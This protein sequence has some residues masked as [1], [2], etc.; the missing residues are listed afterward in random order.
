ME[1]FYIEKIFW[2]EQ[3]V[4][5]ISPLYPWVSDRSHLG[6]VTITASKPRGGFPNPNSQTSW[7]L[8]LGAGKLEFKSVVLIGLTWSRGEERLNLRNP[9]F[10]QDQCHS[11][12]SGAD[13]GNCRAEPAS[14][15]MHTATQEGQR[16]ARADLA[17]CV[18][19][20][21]FSL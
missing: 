9:G 10:P 4:S 12:P 3:F 16:K 8:G 21:K 1:R 20:K 11:P 19:V 2:R 14:R 18:H 5:T 15:G 6:G 17:Q 13:S 7:G